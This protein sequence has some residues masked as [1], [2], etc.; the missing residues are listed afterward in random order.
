[1]CLIVHRFGGSNLPND[2]IDLNS[3]RNADGFGIAWRDREGGLHHAKYGPQSFMKF[4]KQLKRLDRHPEIEYT[5]H[6]RFATT[7]APCRDLSHPFSYMDPIEGEVLVFHN[8]VINIDAPKGESDTSQF[9]K[10]VLANLPSGWWREA[11]FMFLV[12]SAIGGSRMLMMTKSETIYINEDSWNRTSGL[13]YSTDPGG[14][15]S[16]YK[17]GTGKTYAWA[18]YSDKGKDTTSKY[19]PSG[20]NL[21]T[22]VAKSIEERSCDLRVVDVDAFPDGDDDFDIQTWEHS[23]HTVESLGDRIED[24]EEATVEAIC[25][26][27]QTMGEVYVIN[28]ETFIDIPHGVPSNEDDE[29]EDEDAILRLTDGG[30]ASMLYSTH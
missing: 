18:G 19:L 17:A 1:M 29:D 25:V 26:E 2:V 3:K 4:R 13:M 14:S 30:R 5:A 16:K 10:A 9:V 22:P 20:S 7:G 23:G 21:L 6:F 24:G 11:H 27:C 8:G 12:E 15:H 28:G